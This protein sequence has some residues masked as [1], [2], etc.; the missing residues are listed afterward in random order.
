MNK[1]GSYTVEASL[2]LPVFIL[3]VVSLALIIVI[4]S[5]CENIVFVSSITINE[6]D[7]QAKYDKIGLL[8]EQTLKHQVLSQNEKINSYN[9]T[10]VDYLY[11]SDD[12]EDLIA[13]DSSVDF[14]VVNPIGINGRT[15]FE[16]GIL[17]RGYTGKEETC[18][19]VPVDEFKTDCK[20]REVIIFPKY[21]MKYHTDGCVI[22]KRYADDDNWIR[23]NSEDA[24][25]KGYEPCKLCGGIE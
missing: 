5:I 18:P 24:I 7:R 25:R 13:I 23:I 12:I 2:T 11:Y 19:C 9:I 21:G 4:I 8:T 3:S 15:T 6:I 14:K 17:S 10:N 22:L 16:L 1:K 20:Y